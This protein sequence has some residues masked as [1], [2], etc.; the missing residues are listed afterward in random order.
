[1]HSRASGADKRSDHGP[2]CPAFAARQ[3][4]KRLSSARSRSAASRSRSTSTP[5]ARI[6][7]SSSAI[8]AMRLSSDTTVILHCNMGAARLVPAFHRGGRNGQK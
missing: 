5:R 7:A 8:A 4:T 6:V 3:G 1:M 2:A